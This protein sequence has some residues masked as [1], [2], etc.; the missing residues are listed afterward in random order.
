MQQLKYVRLKVH[1]P[2]IQDDENILECILKPKNK[3][4]MSRFAK[5]NTTQ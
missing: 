3:L 2:H 1:V 5:I 4:Q